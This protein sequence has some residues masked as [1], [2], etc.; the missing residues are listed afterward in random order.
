LAGCLSLDRAVSGGGGLL[1]GGGLSAA[2][3]RDGAEGAGDGGDGG[4][5]GKLLSTSAPKS[6]LA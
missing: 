3:E 4:P 1:A 2:A 5:A 6:F